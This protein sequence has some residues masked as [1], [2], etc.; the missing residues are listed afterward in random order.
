[1]TNVRRLIKFTLHCIVLWR[2]SSNNH[3]KRSFYTF[4]MWKYEPQKLS[5]NNCCTFCWHRYSVHTD[6]PVNVGPTSADFLSRFP[7]SKIDGTNF[8]WKIWVQRIYPITNILKKILSVREFISW[9]FADNS[10]LKDSLILFF[11]I[12][13][14]HRVLFKVAFVFPSS[15]SLSF[16]FRN[17]L[18][19]HSFVDVS[20]LIVFW[21]FFNSCSWL[22]QFI[23]FV[24]DLSSQTV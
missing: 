20:S 18:L 16:S 8:Y 13:W 15:S 7:R 21:A 6:C 19:K 3:P 9:F 2:P 23:I 5:L 24:S 4:F 1:M 17:I 14:S 10:W 11:A 12:N 22:Q